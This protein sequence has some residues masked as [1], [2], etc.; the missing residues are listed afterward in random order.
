MYIECAAGLYWSSK[1]H[2]LLTGE[3]TSGFAMMW[4][5]VISGL[6]RAN[7][8]LAG[9]NTCSIKQYKPRVLQI[10]VGIYHQKPTLISLLSLK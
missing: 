3:P 5:I 9:F 8:L 7:V 6:G 10:F 2:P 4:G 1:C